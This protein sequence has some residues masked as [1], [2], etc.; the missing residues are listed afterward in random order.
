MFYP[1]RPTAISF[2]GKWRRRLLL[3]AGVLALLALLIVP[4]G[5]VEAGSPG[6][7][8]A[9]GPQ[10]CRAYHT[11]QRG[12]TL[13]QIAL[14]YGTSWPVLAQAN[15]LPDPDHIYAGQTLCIPYAGQGGMPPVATVANA[16]FLNVRS[17]PGVN[18]QVV[19]VI[20]RGTQVHMLGRNSASSWVYI[21]TP[22]GNTGWVNA[23][24]LSSS[25]PVHTLPVMDGAPPP[26]QVTGIVT[27]YYL[28][29]RSGPGVGF[30][31]VDVLSRGQT[32]PVTHRTA[33]GSWVRILLPGGQPAWVNSGYLRLSA[34]LGSLPV[35]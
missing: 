6:S 14:Q 30:P 33:D 25:T 29:A 9:Q 27:A 19:E 20:A 28:N 35:G 11:V 3:V 21:Q 26:V 13:H 2:E 31:I 24:Y 23:S 1:I 32:V 10:G 5:L 7:P 34:P 8:G 22:G 4:A 18:F 15:N 16:Y 17:G 12:E